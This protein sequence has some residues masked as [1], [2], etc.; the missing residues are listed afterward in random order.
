MRE[1]DWKLRLFLEEWYLD[2][3]RSGLATNRAVELYNL[4]NDIG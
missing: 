4:K 3:R 1:G 2:G